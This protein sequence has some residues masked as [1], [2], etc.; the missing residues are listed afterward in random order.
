[1][2]KSALALVLGITFVLSQSACFQGGVR[3]SPGEGVAIG[4]C[5]PLPCAHMKV[6]EVPVLPQSLSAAVRDRIAT[7]IAEVLYAPLDEAASEFT[8]ESL[9]AQIEA[10]QEEF[11]AQRLSDAPL[12]W[13]LERKAAVLFSNDDILTVDVTNMGYFGGAHGFDERTL[14]CFDLRDGKR[15]SLKELIN[16]NSSGA[17]Q[18]VAEAEFRRV[19]GVPLGRSLQDEGFFVAPGEPFRVTENFGVVEGGILLHYNPYE[20]GPYVMG[21]TDVLLPGEAITP[22]LED[23]KLRVAHIFDSAASNR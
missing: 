11:I 2:S 13:T 20:I 15:L 21:E 18:Q 17:L 19:R 12:D 4:A 14:L 23:G 7:Q 22:L 10:R 8:H 1:M 5:N 9:V 3:P 16:E 6:S